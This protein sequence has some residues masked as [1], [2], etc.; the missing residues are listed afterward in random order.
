MFIPS[1]A[2]DGSRRHRLAVGVMLC[3][4]MVVLGVGLTGAALQAVGGGV[5]PVLGFGAAAVSAY[6]LVWWSARYWYAAFCEG[7]RPEPVPQPAPWPWLPP[8]LVIGVAA[9]VTGI[10]ALSSGDSSGWFS[11]GL[12][13]L[14]G[15]P[16][17]VGLFV[18]VLIRLSAKEALDDSAS[19]PAEPAR[20]RRD[21]GSVG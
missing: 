3:V 4:L 1:S 16:A 2:L 7:R 9:A 21:W 10:R 15:L 19:P 20:P 6:P 14:F 12:G 11:L 18:L 8:P 17:L 5:L 13:A